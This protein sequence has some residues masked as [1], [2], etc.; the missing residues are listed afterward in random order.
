MSG[1]LCRASLPHWRAPIGAAGA[2]WGVGVG[3][4]Q[5]D[6]A[7]SERQSKTGATGDRL[8]VRPARP[9]PARPGPKKKS[10]A[11]AAQ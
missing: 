1:R 10:R 6:L 7:G 2:C 3:G 5:V 4:G 8:K 9:D 11:K